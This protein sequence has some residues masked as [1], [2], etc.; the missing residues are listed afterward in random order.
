MNYLERS[1]PQE[2]T[3]EMRNYYLKVV[4]ILEC[5][6]CQNRNSSLHRLDLNLCFLFNPGGQVLM[7]MWWGKLWLFRLILALEDFSLLRRVCLKLNWIYWAPQLAQFIR[8]LRG[9]SL[10]VCPRKKR[11][12]R[13]LKFSYLYFIVAVVCFLLQPLLLFVSTT[14]HS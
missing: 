11:S 10:T 14:F 8:C 7:M 5:G 3:E 12:I 13:D 9:C 1:P 6:L 4:V 2:V